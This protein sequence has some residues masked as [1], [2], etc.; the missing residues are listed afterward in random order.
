[1]FRFS[2]AL[3]CTRHT[4]E[5]IAIQIREI[6]GARV[7]PVAAAQSG[8]PDEVQEIL[9]EDHG[10]LLAFTRARPEEFSITKSAAGVWHLQA[11]IGRKRTAPCSTFAHIAAAPL[12]PPATAAQPRTE[13]NSAPL[14][15]AFPIS[16][17]PPCEQIGRAD[18]PAYLTPCFSRVSFAVK[19]KYHCLP[20]FAVPFSALA[21]VVS[22]PSVDALLEALKESIS[23]G[24]VTIVRYRRDVFVVPS[25]GAGTSH[26]DRLYA[27]WAVPSYDFCRVARLLSCDEPTAVQELEYRA[28]NMLTTPLVAVLLS[29]PLRIK[30]TLVE[31][32]WDDVAVVGGSDAS[33]V[34]F[35]PSSAFAPL[36]KHLLSVTYMVDPENLAR[37]APCAQMY[38]E[39]T[40]ED[41]QTVFADFNKRSDKKTFKALKERRRIIRAMLAKRFPLGNPLIDADVTSMLLFDSIE[42][43]SGYINSGALRELLPDGGK[44]ACQTGNEFF[45]KFPHLFNVVEESMTKLLVQRSDCGPPP[46]DKP[47]SENELILCIVGALPSP[48]IPNQKF[49]VSFIVTRVTSHVLSELK[50]Q[51]NTPEAFFDR[52]PMVFDHAFSA[53]G[54]QHTYSTT[55]EKVRAWES[56]AVR[57]LS[58][59]LLGGDADS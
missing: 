53:S 56:S 46:R 25:A 9:G 26:A 7:V 8:L 19:G 10:G 23:A 20:T 55:P 5:A 14:K 36:V 58:S 30:C 43:V 49:H 32:E 34:G 47:L 57:Q 31:S 59:E 3:I 52:F 35:N 21:E 11:A 24:A 6:L 1:M 22:A 18:L 4:A 15:D 40:L 42:H 13:I 50:R 37:E 48:L 45:K 38:A 28:A 54:G 17:R 29:F 41:M 2:P 39:H 33:G 44:T 16:T 51:Y 12:A 27:Q